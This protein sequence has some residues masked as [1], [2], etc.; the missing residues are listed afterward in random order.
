MRWFTSS[1]VWQGRKHSAFWCYLR[2]ASLFGWN[3][4]ILFCGK[5]FPGYYFLYLFR[6]PWCSDY[7]FWF[8]YSGVSGFSDM[9]SCISAN[10]MSSFQSL[11][12]LPHISMRPSF[13]IPFWLSG[14]MCLGFRT[15]HPSLITFS[16]YHAHMCRFFR[17]IKL[18]PQFLL[19]RHSPLTVLSVLCC[20]D[21]CAWTWSIGNQWDFL[22]GAYAIIL[23]SP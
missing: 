10:F 6:L 20:A 9:H 11:R 17:H 3:Y 2:H 16:R 23:H 8:Y 1:T 5:V 22:I 13:G 7:L 18:F 21:H 4:L 12:L 15:I 19:L 14:L